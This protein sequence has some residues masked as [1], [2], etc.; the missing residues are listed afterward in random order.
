[1][2]LMQDN[3]RSVGWGIIGIGNHA[4]TR[5]APAIVRA[6]NASLAAVYSRDIGRANDFAARHG[7]TARACDAIADLVADP[8]VEIVYIASPNS[9]HAEH[10]L[11]CLA[12]GK[13]VLVDKPMAT[14]PADA[15]RMIATAE[16]GG[17]ELAVAFNQRYHPGHQ[18][19]RQLIEDGSLG[20]VVFARV[21]VSAYGD[22]AR[23]AAWRVPGSKEGGAIMNTGPHAVDLL[24]YVMGGR[25]VVEVSALADSIP[26]E[27]TVAG[28]RLDD[29]VMVEF[30]T[31][32]RMPYRR[33]GISVHGSGGW[34]GTRGTVTYDIAGELETT[35]GDVT[36]VERW[37]AD[38]CGHDE[39]TAEVDWVSRSLRGGPPA[40]ASGRDGLA[41]LEVL[42]ALAE[43]AATGR[44][45][46]LD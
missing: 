26:D 22:P 18:R 25:R 23:T 20:T 38:P 5:M 1:M 16:A 14:E 4:N 21:E 8:A 39:F 33:S 15:R 28:M 34:L 42:A 36:N 9:L 7:G 41:C 32:R 31:S 27:L 40:L 19:A 12:A 3:S 44:A 37:T 46:R 2:R 17:V 45:V 13:R 11:A 35:L 24:L 43:S 6:G 30:V 29:G 10:T